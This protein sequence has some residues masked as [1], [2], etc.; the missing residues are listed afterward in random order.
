MK[1]LQWLWYFWFCNPERFRGEGH[2]FRY[3]IRRFWLDIETLSGNWKMRV[4][5]SEHPFAYLAA[6]VQQGKEENLF[7]FAE[8]MYY[9]SSTL[10]RDQT[11]VNDIQK[12]MHDYEERLIKAEQESGEEEDPEDQA[13][14]EVKKIQEYVEASPKERK[15]MER[16]TNKKI[17]KHEKELRNRGE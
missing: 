8:I 10:T 17:K 3:R 13:L 12:A 11:L 16:E 5:A 9:L 1:K 6:G 7:G 4:M 14:D 2:G 15:R